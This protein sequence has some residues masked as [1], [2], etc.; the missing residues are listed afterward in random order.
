MIS[1]AKVARNMKTQHQAQRT[2]NGIDMKS[3]IGAMAAA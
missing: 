3:P 1:M 2:K